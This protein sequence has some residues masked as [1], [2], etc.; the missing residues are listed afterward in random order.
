METVEK[1][2][3]K[4]K[5]MLKVFFRFLSNFGDNSVK[6]PRKFW[7]YLGKIVRYFGIILEKHEKNCEKIGGEEL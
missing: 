1:I 7:S 3:R 5:S 6:N 4:F 2:F